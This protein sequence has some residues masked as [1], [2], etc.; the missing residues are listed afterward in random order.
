[1][2]RKNTIRQKTVREVKPNNFPQPVFLLCSKRNNAETINT[3]RNTLMKLIFKFVVRKPP[4]VAP[5]KIPSPDKRVLYASQV[6]L[7]CCVVASN[8]KFADDRLKPLQ[9]SPE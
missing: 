9:T 3:K 2:C 4:T 7:L 6:A 8:M 5:I 1:M